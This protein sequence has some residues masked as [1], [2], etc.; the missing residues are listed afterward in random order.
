M[1]NNQPM[2]DPRPAR[3]LTSREVAKL[4]GGHLGSLAGLCPPDVL[5]AAV[6]FYADERTAATH[7]EFFRGLWQQ[8]VQTGHVI[9]EDDPDQISRQ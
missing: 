6:N 8:A 1:K 9:P 2:L 3:Q 7:D 4:L 5:R